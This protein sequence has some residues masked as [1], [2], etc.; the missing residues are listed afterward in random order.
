MAE[1]GES[2]SSGKEEKMMRPTLCG[3]RE[4]ILS[5]SYVGVIG[6]LLD[7]PHFPSPSQNKQGKFGCVQVLKVCDA[8]WFLLCSYQLGII[9]APSDIAARFVHPSNYNA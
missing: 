9:L 5:L 6:G 8:I 2:E 4:T 7:I 3:N 1:K